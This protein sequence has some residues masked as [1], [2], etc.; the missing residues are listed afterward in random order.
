VT[1]SGLRLI[2]EMI[3]DSGQPS[4]S[5]NADANRADATNFYTD[6][7]RAVQMITSGITGQQEQQF[8]NQCNTYHI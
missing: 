1:A 3:S 8:A 6:P 5:E 7:A 2:A 4:R